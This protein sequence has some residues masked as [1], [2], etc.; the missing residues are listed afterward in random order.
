MT[1]TK[2][3][4]EAEAESESES[5]G[6]SE[7]QQRGGEEFGFGRDDVTMGMAMVMDEVM[8][9]SMGVGVGVGVGVGGRPIS[10]PL[11]TTMSVAAAGKVKQVKSKSSKIKEKDGEKRKQRKKIKVST[12]AV[13]VID[14]EFATDSK[15]AT[16]TTTTTAP[17]TATATVKRSKRRE[18]DPTVRQR[19]HRDRPSIKIKTSLDHPPVHE[20]PS[21]TE[22]AGRSALR[23]VRPRNLRPAPTTTTVGGVTALKTGR[24]GYDL[25]T[26]PHRRLPASL[27]S[28]AMIR[29]DFSM[30]DLEAALTL[31][32]VARDAE[33]IASA[34]EEGIGGVVDP[35][36]ELANAQAKK[37][38]ARRKNGVVRTL[39]KGRCENCGMDEVRLTCGPFGGFS[40]RLVA[41]PVGG[42]VKPERSDHVE[43]GQDV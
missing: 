35:V 8:G 16:T 33:L 10:P 12:T 31:R 25:P 14:D 11:S 37:E 15:N 30:G 18:P 36:E 6:R 40:G 27:C 2:I 38:E 23:T 5:S 17:A 22:D 41:D 19:Q 21:A 1:M 29:A 28:S 7:S 39:Q 42:Y 32:Y 13:E 4:A 24:M 3:P 34:N 43:V 20:R 9:V 26:Q